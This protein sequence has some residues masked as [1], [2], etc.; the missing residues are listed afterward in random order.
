MRSKP[1]AFITNKEWETYL[2][3]KGKQE[4]KQYINYLREKYPRA[5]SSILY[6]EQEKRI[7]EKSKRDNREIERLRKK[8]DGY[9]KKRE[10]EQ[11][12]PPAMIAIAK[13]F[14]KIMPV[15]LTVYSII[16]LIN[17]YWIYQIYKLVKVSGWH[18]FI[19]APYSLYMVVYF[20]ILFIAYKVNVWIYG[21]SER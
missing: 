13:I 7:V 3:I 20:A 11:N 8:I 4:R 12:T 10:R 15:L 6:D 19:E 1:T 17:L 18:G 21:I 14:S 16:G 9:D 2:A 5:A